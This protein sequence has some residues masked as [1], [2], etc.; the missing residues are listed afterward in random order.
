MCSRGILEPFLLLGLSGHFCTGQ[1]LPVATSG[2]PSSE[3]A[4]TRSVPALVHA[5]AS[6]IAEQ[7]RSVAELRQR[8]RIRVG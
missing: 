4:F 8:A 3:L 6:A 1:W 5:A 7:R 2:A